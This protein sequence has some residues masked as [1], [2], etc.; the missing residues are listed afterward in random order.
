MKR[1]KI[2]QIKLTFFAMGIASPIKLYFAKP[3]SQRN[4]ISYIAQFN[5]TCQFY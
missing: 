4:K 3:K 5:S 2:G 1:Q